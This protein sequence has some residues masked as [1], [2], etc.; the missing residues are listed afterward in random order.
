MTAI[1]AGVVFVLRTVGLPLWHTRLEGFD[2]RHPAFAGL[3]AMLGDVA[4]MDDLYTREH[5]EPSTRHGFNWLPILL[6]VQGFFVTV[7]L[8]NLMIAR[9]TST[10]ETIHAESRFYR[11][12]QFSNFVT[13]FKDERALPPPFNLLEMIIHF[14][15]SIKR[16]LQGCSKHCGTDDH[17]SS[18][19]PGFA[20]EMGRQAS[21]RLERFTRQY[22][23][24]FEEQSDLDQKRRT[25]SRVAAIA[26]DIRT[27]HNIG[28][29]CERLDAELA[30]TDAHV[31]SLKDDMSGALR[32]LE[33]RCT[34]LDAKLD[35]LL[36]G[37]AGGVPAVPLDALPSPT[38]LPTPLPPPSNPWTR[39]AVSIDG[40]TS[41]SEVRLTQAISRQSRRWPQASFFTSG[42]AATLSDTDD[43]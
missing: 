12:V 4:F 1:L 9:M 37:S 7:F 38:P 15:M 16:C 39:P 3:W 8:V 14:G 20:I 28:R 43:I 29:M 40:A 22:A 36:A 24:A 27:L 26:K 41:L 42:E 23:R 31:T 32:R 5:A 33:D 11:A 10:Y 25:D 2:M 35:A 30:S 21:L 19:Q 18:H 34:R 17:A 6:W 13:E